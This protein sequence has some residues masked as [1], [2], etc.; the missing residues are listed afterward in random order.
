MDVGIG[1]TTKKLTTRFIFEK[2]T[3][4]GTI[5]LIFTP[6][7]NTA[8]SQILDRS[9]HVIMRNTYITCQMLNAGS[10]YHQFARHEFNTPLALDGVTEHTASI[11]VSGNTI[12]MKVDSY[13]YS[14]T[15][16]DGTYD[17]TDFYGRY[18]LF[19]FYT[20]G[21]RDVIAMPEYTYVKLENDAGIVLLEDNFNRPDGVLTIAPNGVPYSLFT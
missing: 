14:E 9:I 5:A 17:I 18:A 2:G 13:T 20:G 21:N 8:G 16:T 19:E 4:S 7:G 3:E 12:T 11:E 1:R 15:F 6:R 10:V